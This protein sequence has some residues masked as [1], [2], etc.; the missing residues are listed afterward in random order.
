MDT[1]RV[2]NIRSKLVVIRSDASQFIKSYVVGVDLC[3]ISKITIRSI[4]LSFLMLRIIGK[5]NNV[6]FAN[7]LV[8][9]L[10]KM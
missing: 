9:E 6:H 3:I 5:T 4:W 7:S 10:G 1:V 2:D 8:L